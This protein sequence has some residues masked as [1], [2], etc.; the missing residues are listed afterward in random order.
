MKQ[1]SS[2]EKDLAT[3]E[4]MAQ[5]YCDAHHIGMNKDAVNLCIEC[6]EA[7]I[8]TLNRTQVCPNGHIHN[9]QDCDIKCQRGD[10]Q[11]RI[12]AIMAYSAPRMLWRHP[13]MTF[14]YLR[15]KFQR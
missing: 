1:K 3:L 14:T 4:A 5:I 12:K 7:V 2:Y 11:S 10:G 9:C 8:A 13:L 15:K 6:R